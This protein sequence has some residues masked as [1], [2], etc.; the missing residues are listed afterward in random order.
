MSVDESEV[1]PRPG[2]ERRGPR[3]LRLSVVIPL[4]DDRDIAPWSVASWSREQ[5]YPRE[6]YEVIAIA[7]QASPERD[8]RV[9]ALL[10]PHDAFLRF[11]RCNPPELYNAGALAARG[12]TLFFTEPHVV[13]DRDCLA[14]LIEFLDSHAFDGAFCG[15][16][17][18]N[19]DLLAVLE[20]QLFSD[21]FPNRVHEDHWN[22]VMIRGFAMDRQRFL[23]EGMFDAELHHFA[24]P[25]LS[26]RLHARG[27]RFGYAERAWVW[28]CNNVRFSNLFPELQA[29]GRG[30]FRYRGKTS[31][32]HVERYLKP[33]ID[34]SMGELSRSE[35][36]RAL[37]WDV[38]KNLPRVLAAGDWTKVAAHAR[39]L[40][41]HLLTTVFGPRAAVLHA[42][43]K[44][45][46]AALRFWLW[47][48]H[49]EKR[50]ASYKTAW[51]RAIQVGRMISLAETLE[52]PREEV[53]DQNAYDLA[54]VDETQLAGFHSVENWN[55][56][57]F[58]WS[59][60]ESM[61]H[62]ALPVGTYEVALD[63][64]PLR[65]DDEPLGLDVFFDRRHVASFP[66]GVGNS[67]LVFRIDKDSFDAGATEHRL[68]FLT[69]AWKTTHS[70][71]GNRVLGLP[72][73]GV[74]FTPV[75]APHTR[76]A[77][78]T[79]RPAAR[80][81]A[82]EALRET[83]LKPHAVLQATKAM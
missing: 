26:A 59:A 57:A 12:R 71:L 39:F 62:V 77:G 83:N 30:E 53:P 37:S 7:G 63:A 69:D 67:P 81:K 50:L 41:R 55:G 73:C 14:E 35:N 21:D 72:L 2:S 19:D 44:R 70:T 80:S 43:L 79:A 4:E 31:T 60:P 45:D 22:K 25:A 17:R 27:L 48:W 36:A 34:W 58:R 18:L 52:K 74:R 38:L 56:R 47:A 42:S 20:E 28:H 6:R 64:L 29:Y 40:K 23:S 10:A 46:L 1:V 78:P 66:R 65:P 11:P 54:T 16:E 32:A 13:A 49:P 68:V 61:L 5:S 33:H 3:N 51:N 24:E 75:D 15:S 82:H 76:L 9:Q 8:A